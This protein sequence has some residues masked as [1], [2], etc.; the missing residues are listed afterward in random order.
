MRERHRAARVLLLL[1]AWLAGC[2]GGGGESDREE[3]ADAVRG[4]LEAVADRD[5]DAACAL[6]TREAQLSVFRAKR[7]HAGADHPGEA[8]ANVVR[9]FGPLY[10]RGRLR[11][12][13][14]SRVEVDGERAQARA[15]DVAVKLEKV[16]GEWKL[17]VPGVGQAVGDT[18]PPARG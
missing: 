2:G 6:L 14:V 5:G 7:A 18:P 15:D 17:A 1:G 16:S 12:V 11:G 10:G 4:Y 8:C 3:V 13:A 9:S